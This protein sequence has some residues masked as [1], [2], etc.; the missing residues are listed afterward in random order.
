MYKHLYHG[1]HKLSTEVKKAKVYI[2]A[3]NKIYASIDKG[4]HIIIVK[5][6]KILSI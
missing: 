1:N 4:F 5:S 3:Q 2:E 6:E